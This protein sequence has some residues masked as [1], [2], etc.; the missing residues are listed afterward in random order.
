MRGKIGELVNGELANGQRGI[1]AVMVQ[2]FSHQSCSLLV[3]QMKRSHCHTSQMSTLFSVGCYSLIV[4][5]CSL[6]Q[7]GLQFGYGWRR[8]GTKR[9][10]Q[11][12]R[13]YWQRRVPFIRTLSG[14]SSER[15]AS[16]MMI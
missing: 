11:V 12:A 4:D 16:H 1:V 10:L 7:S 13:A 15:N 2:Q 9:P 14:V 6:G 5:C 8:D 3:S